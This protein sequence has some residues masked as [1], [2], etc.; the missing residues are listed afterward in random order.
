[1]EDT[2]RSALHGPKPWNNSVDPDRL[3]LPSV[4]VVEDDRD[5]RELLVTL[6]EMAGFDVVA[7][8]HAEAGLDALREQS[9][10]LLLTDY[11]L[12][13]H[14]GLWLLDEAES[15]GLIQGTPVLIVTAHP[16]VDS[17]RYEVIQKPFDL[18]QLVDRVRQRVEGTSARGGRR[19]EKRQAARGRGMGSDGPEC[20]DPVELILY[21]SAGSER[22]SDAVDNLKKVLE[23][24]NASRFKLTV[25]DLPAKAGVTPPATV[26][27]APGLV[28]GK[29]GPRTFILGHITSPELMLE[30]LADCDG[31]VN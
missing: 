17:K 12:P 20:P 16:D 30:L 7:C 26:P 22:S 14:S 11:A 28:R 13:R 3:A 27:P 10:D 6:L 4:L 1:M 19:P 29:P 23:R 15:E 9:F 31:G 25:C 2:S 21:V 8:P 18:D 24:L 5:V